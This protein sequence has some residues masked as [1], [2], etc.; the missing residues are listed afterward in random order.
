MP[1]RGL[2]TEMSTTLQTQSCECALLTMGV[3][4][5][6]GFPH[7]LESPPGNFSSWKFQCLE[8]LGKSLSSW[9]NILENHTFFHNLKWKTSSNSILPSLFLL[10]LTSILHTTVPF[11]PF[12]YLLSSL[13]LNIHAPWKGPGNIVMVVLES[14]GFFVG[15]R[16]GTVLYVLSIIATSR[17]SCIWS[18]C[19][20]LCLCSIRCAAMGTGN[21]R[22]V[23]ISRR[24]LDRGLSFAGARIP[25]G[26]SS[27]LSGQCLSTH[28][29][30]YALQ[31]ALCYLRGSSQNFLASTY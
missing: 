23:S 12:G 22:H 25:D 2:E 29:A 26:V 21:V 18:L 8:S 13:Y 16:M 1:A 17:D 30:V 3:L 4:P 6:L 20:V 11:F 27:W 19:H 14:R 31:T 5:L 28:E 15:K 10:L 9:K 24:W 7:L